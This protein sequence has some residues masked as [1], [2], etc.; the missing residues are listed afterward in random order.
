MM[1]HEITEKVG[2]YKTR[3][4]IGR[5]HGSGHGKTSG[6]GHK[7]AG[8]R[9]G[10][11]RRAYFEGGQMS[12]ARRIPKRGFTNAEFRKLYHV[13]NIKELE[14][15]FDDGAEITA[16]DLAAHGVIRDTDRPLKVLGEGE[17]TKK[18]TVTA[19]KFSSGARSKIEAA[20]GVV[21]EVARPKWTRQTAVKNESKKKGRRNKRASS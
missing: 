14:S 2:R 1:I 5:G 19:A 7:G 15:R 13:V 12:F 17:L 10:Y 16:E 20:G 3:K 4:R 18:F 11:T 9:S 8:S 21:T 6:R